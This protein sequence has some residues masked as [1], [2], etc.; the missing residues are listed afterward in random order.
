MPTM[1]GYSKPI[2]TCV[3]PGGAIATPLG[4]CGGID[5]ADELLSVVQVSDP[6]IG[7][8]TELLTEATIPAAD[9]IELST[10][11]TTGDFL[12]VSW[13]ENE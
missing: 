3:V 9:Q 7:A 13:A 2:G 5:P 11:V 8:G 10:T 6:Q 1:I 12:L 4:P